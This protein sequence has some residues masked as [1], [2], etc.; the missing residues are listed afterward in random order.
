MVPKLQAIDHVHIFV[1][2]RAGSELWYKNVLGLHPVKEL[3]FWTTS[4]GPLTIANDDKSIHL[5]L[6][7]SEKNERAVVAFSV[8]G[9]EYL[10]CFLH[11]NNAGLTVSHNNH[12][13]SWSVY[14]NDPDGNPFEI[15]SY[16]YEFIRL[17]L[18]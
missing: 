16:D 15:T 7:G 6:F 13:V 14:F 11:L 8:S 2:N 12:D 5:A 10:K 9:Q 3:E 4:G 17:A 1:K 18:I